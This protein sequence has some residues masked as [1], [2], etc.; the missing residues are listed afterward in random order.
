LSNKRTLLLAVLALLALSWSSVQAGVW[1]RG[2]Y[3][4]HPYY[5]RPYFRPAF[6]VYLG[7]PP[8]VIGAPAYV[9]P[10]PVYV[11]PVPVAAPTTVAP[12]APVSPAPAAP[13][14]G[15]PPPVPIQ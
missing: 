14:S 7:V 5:Y 11:Q 9:V 10:A 4:Y 8:V 15:L 2:G 13:S 1:V 6:G 12:A 3:Y